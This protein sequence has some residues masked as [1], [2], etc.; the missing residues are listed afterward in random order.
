ML[1]SSLPKGSCG[2]RLCRAFLNGK[3]C[4]FGSSNAQFA[5]RGCSKFLL[6]TA[7]AFAF[8]CHRLRRAQK[9]HIRADVIR[10]I[11]PIDPND[12]LYGASMRLGKTSIDSQQLFYCAQNLFVIQLLLFTFEIVLIHF[13]N[14]TF[15]IPGS[16]L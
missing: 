13:I 15:P 11:L 5:G 10:N 14:G 16:F 7:N 9:L 3:L 2:A 6:G 12:L 1:C 8:S 4:S